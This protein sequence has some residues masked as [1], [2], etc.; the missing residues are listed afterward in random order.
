MDPVVDW[1]RQHWVSLVLI[2]LGAAG[3]LGW[4]LLTAIMDGVVE[5]RSDIHTPGRGRVSTRGG[6]L[7]ASRRSHSWEE[8][9]RRLF[10]GQCGSACGRWIE[11]KR[12]K[13]TLTRRRVGTKS[14]RFVPW[15]CFS[16][17]RFGTRM[18]C[19][20]RCVSALSAD[21]LLC[22]RTF[23]EGWSGPAI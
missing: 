4:P 9:W 18:A 15:F 19:T 7:E 3:D 14:D 12:E 8:I 11:R 21:L 2:E 16:N 5:W 23:P 20:A 6:A 22:P 10:V 1:E 13:A 17:C